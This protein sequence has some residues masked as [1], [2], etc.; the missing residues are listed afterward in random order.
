MQVILSTSDVRMQAAF[1]GVLISCLADSGGQGGKFRGATT[2]AT[3]VRDAGVQNGLIHFLRLRGT[4]PLHTVGGGYR[5]RTMSQMDWSR[6]VYCT[7]FRAT[8]R[9]SMAGLADSYDTGKDFSTMACEWL[10]FDKCSL[11]I[12]GQFWQKLI[13]STVWLLVHWW[14]L[15]SG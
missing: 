14:Q 2:S 11:P 9:A 1:R 12:R 5:C 10:L 3:G 4:G 7:I 8:S 15:C 13:K 6:G